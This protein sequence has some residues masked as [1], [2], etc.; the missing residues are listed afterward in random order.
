MYT[1]VGCCARVEVL[2]CNRFVIVRRRDAQGGYC[3]HLNLKR[4]ESLFIF[5]AKQQCRE[6]VACIVVKINAEAQAHGIGFVQYGG[7]KGIRLRLGDWH[8]Y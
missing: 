1:V 5:A 3:R 7:D 8:S 2:F 6:I 4:R